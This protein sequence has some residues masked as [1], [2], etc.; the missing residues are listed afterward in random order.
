LRPEDN[1]AAA[2]SP[3]RSPLLFSIGFVFVLRKIKR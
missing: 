2:S 3:L 1:N